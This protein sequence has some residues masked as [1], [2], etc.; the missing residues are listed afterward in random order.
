MTT[1]RNITLGDGRNITLIDQGQKAGV[2][3][4]YLHG[5]PGSNKDHA[6][7]EA[8]YQKQG[9]RLI[10]VNRPGTGTSGFHSDWNALSFA[11]ELKQ[12]LDSLG[13]GRAAVVG[14]SA[15]GLHACAFAQRHPDYVSK[16]GLLSSVAPFD[17]PSL[18][19]KRSEA[20]RQFHDAARDNPDALLEQ[21]SSITSADDL[22]ALII[23]LVSPQ[24][25]AVLSSPETTTQFLL[26]ASDVLTQGL[27]PV[28]AEIAI[29]NSPWGFSV[30]DI[31]ADT[32][33]WHGTADI[34]VPIECS[35]Y[36]AAHIPHARASYLEGAGH[37][38]SFAQ[39][40]EIVR[41]M[42]S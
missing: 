32:H 13:I 20:I 21:L 10:S 26:S 12:V 33:I 18:S 35:Q 41:A 24:D 16:L 3:I 22:L 28:I 34:N 11:D 5:A 38:F 14:F 31:T 36:L 27:Q 40:Q 9:I 2:P 8:F 15:G 42:I 7:H 19:E 23:S 4:V 6:H 30:S 25:Q 29:I 37:Y 1:E 39:W 17:I